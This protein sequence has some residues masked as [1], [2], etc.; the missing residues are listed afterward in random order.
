M[1]QEYHLLRWNKNT[2]FFAGQIGLEH[3]HVSLKPGRNPSLLSVL[4]A[5]R[6][7]DR[8]NRNYPPPTKEDPSLRK[9]VKAL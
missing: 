7:A 1:T 8:K 9:L 6:F 2:V 3:V 4:S 5:R